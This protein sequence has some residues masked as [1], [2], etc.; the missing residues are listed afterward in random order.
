MATFSLSD[1]DYFETCMCCGYFFLASIPKS[2][3]RQIC[4]ANPAAYQNDNISYHKYFSRLRVLVK[5]FS[6]LLGSHYNTN[7][8][9][10]TNPDKDSISAPLIQKFNRFQHKSN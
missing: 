4:R 1:L 7:G 5:I 3:T 2:D 9:K 6:H 8:K 10:S